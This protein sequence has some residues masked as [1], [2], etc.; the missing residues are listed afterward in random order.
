ML[1]DYERKQLL[2]RIERDG[3][4]VGHSI[5]DVILIDGDELQLSEFV[6]EAKK[7]GEPP[8]SDFESLKE[9]KQKLRK[10]RNDR[11]ERVE[12]DDELTS[13]EGERL[14]NEVIGLDRALTALRNPQSD[15]NIEQESQRKK[16][17]SKK[18][19]M[20]FLKKVGATGNNRGR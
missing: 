16:A 7:L 17:A 19:W 3:A 13:K 4:T 6:F 11:F 14:A 10:G 18:R 9:V 1:K 12:E 15:A 8:A 2:A 5:P 20:N